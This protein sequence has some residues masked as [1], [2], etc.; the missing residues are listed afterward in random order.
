MI[1][2]FNFGS[3][4]KLYHP[5]SLL[6]GGVLM[7]HPQEKF[8]FIEISLIVMGLIIGIVAIAKSLVILGFLA[9]YLIILSLFCEA[10]IQLSIQQKTAGSKQLIKAIILFALIT[11]LILQL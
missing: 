10:F 8:L 1:H 9:L 11:Y 6:K 2:Q 4:S 7:K 3:T 5:F